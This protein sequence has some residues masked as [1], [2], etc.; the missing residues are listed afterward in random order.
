MKKCI[1]IILNVLLTVSLILITM[2]FIIENIVVKT[3]SREILAKKVSGYFLDEVV[4]DV[5]I[6]TLGIMENNIRNSQYTT[7]ITSKFIQTIV[8]NVVYN[9]NIKFDISNEIDSL[10]LENMPKEFDNEKVNDTKEYLSKNIVNIEKNIEE[11]IIDSAKDYYL[12]ILKTYSIV[13]NIYFRIGIILMCIL[14]I[15]GLVII[16]KGKTLKTIQIS[17][18]LTMLFTIIAFIIIK[19]SSNFIDQTFE[20]GRLSSINL[21][22]MLIFIIIEFIISVVLFII[23]KRSNL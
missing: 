10:I 15:I 14:I 22:L 7:K 3:F 6:N 4:Y 1:K 19:L 20:G 8:K 21:G 11:D 18:T 5:D 13:T 23:I 2:S 12:P 17:S 9:E 16:E